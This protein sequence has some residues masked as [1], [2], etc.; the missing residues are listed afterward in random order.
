MRRDRKDN[1]M[2]E[3]SSESSLIMKFDELIR[4]IVV[5]TI[6]ETIKFIRKQFNEII[7][8]SVKDRAF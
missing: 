8:K 4:L 3:N 6:S 7:C 5:L 1:F 2:N